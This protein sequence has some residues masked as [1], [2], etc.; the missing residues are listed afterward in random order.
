ML[1]D[2][3]WWEC[4][5]LSGVR[6]GKITNWIPQIKKDIVSTFKWC[7]GCIVWGSYFSGLKPIFEL[8]CS[9]QERYE[10][11]TMG[12]C[13]VSWFI[14]LHRTFAYLFCLLP[15]RV[16]QWWCTRTM[17]DQFLICWTKLWN[18]LLVKKELLK[19][20]TLRYWLHKCIWWRWCAPLLCFI[21]WWLLWFKWCALIVFSFWKLN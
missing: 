1:F 8:K 7:W 4:T 9:N 12:S 13:D 17:K 6:W 15:V 21:I 5:G 2:L 14:W 3:W 11:V 16:W 18:L 19:R 10:P 20:E